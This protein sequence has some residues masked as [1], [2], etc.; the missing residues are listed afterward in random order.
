MGSSVFPPVSNI[1]SAI[2]TLVWDS[3]GTL[4]LSSSLYSVLLREGHVAETGFKN[5]RVTAYQETIHCGI[6]I[7]DS[8][9]SPAIIINMTTHKL[10]N[11]NF[12]I[13]KMGIVIHSIHSIVMIK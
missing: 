6:H 9:M 2:L 11:F 4:I 10:L 13:Y 12:L 5:S 8:V 3:A 7:P 1:K